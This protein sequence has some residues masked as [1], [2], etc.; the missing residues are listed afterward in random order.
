MIRS[1]GADAGNNAYDQWNTA[2]AK[3]YFVE[4]NEGKLVYLDQDDDAFNVAATSLGVA[5]EQAPDQLVAAVRGRLFWKRSG[6]P[7]FAWFDEM[8]ERWLEHR[9]HSV[10]TKRAPEAPPHIALLTLFSMAAE[11]MGSSSKGLKQSEAGF[12][13]QLE[14]LLSVPSEESQRLRTSFRASTEAYWEALALWLEDRDGALGLPS[15]YALTHRYVGLPVS[16]ALV[17]ETERRNL[18]R[19][20]EEQ[21]LLPGTALSHTEMFNALDV[22]IHSARTSANASMIKM[23]ANSDTQDRI[24]DIALA[25]LAAWDGPGHGTDGQTNVSARRCFFTLRESRQRLATVFQLGLVAN[26][27]LVA[28]EEATLAGEHEDISVVLRSGSPG[29]AGVDFKGVLP[30]YASFLEGAVSMTTQSGQTIRRFPKNVLILTRDPV[31]ERYLETDRI[32]PGTPARV[33][34]RLQSGLADAVEKILIDSAQPGYSRLLEGHAGLPAGWVMFDRVQVL[35]S[36]AAALITSKELAGFELRLSA[37]MTLNGGLKLPGRVARWS[38]RSPL[39]LVIASDEDGPFELVMTTLNAETLQAEEK[40]LIHGLL[41][42]YAVMLEDLDIDREDFSLSLRAGKKTLQSISVKLRDSSSPRA[43]SAAAYR[44]LCRDFGDPSWPVTA[45]PA[46]EADRIGIDGL[47]VQE[48]AADS[49]TTREVSIPRTATWSKRRVGNTNR[50]VLRLPPPGPTSCLITGRHHFIFPTFHGGWPQ[51]KWIY[52]ECEQ[53]RLSSRAPTRFTKKTTQR[54]S[55]SNQTPLP[56]L[57]TKEEPNWEVLMDALAYIGSGTAKEFSGL[58]RQHEDTPLFEKR[59]L[60]ALEALAY[61]EVQRDSSHRLTHWEMAASSIG[62]L[63][64]GSWLLAGLWD[65]E[66]VASVEQATQACG[67]RIEQIDVATHASRIIRGMDQTAVAELAADLEVVLRPGAADAL[68]RVLPNI[69]TVGHS[70]TRSSLPDVHECQFFEPVS[71]SW[72]DVDSAE[73]AG[74]FRSRHGYVT[75]YFFR[76]PADVRNGVGARVDVELGKHLAAI[77][78][79]HHLAAYDPESQ[80]LSVPMG[81]ELPGIYGRAAVMASGRFPESDFRTSSLNYRGVEPQTARLLIGK[82]AS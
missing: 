14:D 26:V 70:L 62:G 72:L 50:N 71:A 7:M 56:P 6:V 65:R 21:G 12:Y 51:T 28:D 36:P 37:Q 15:A 35:R 49:T 53:C 20:F 77:Q 60:T 40:V 29:Q 1:T 76:T 52:G 43:A 68:T 75:H 10:E 5:A 74:L 47:L 63:S 23:W 4:E 8:T 58:A 54:K 73:H 41:A 16:Q 25:E 48:E 82:V 81:A 67:G 44:F 34:V 22:W 64:D 13:G 9:N 3:A 66:M 57:S 33:L 27:Q 61:I 24:T 46:V 39:Q 79:G 19:M 17:R 38:A 69:S 80:T 2:L 11:T 18:R 32:A 31:T 55:L 42:P 45:V 78:I 30:D 59:L